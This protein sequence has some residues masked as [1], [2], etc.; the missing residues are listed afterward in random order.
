MS[1]RSRAILPLLVALLPLS[2]SAQRDRGKSEQG[3]PPIPAAKEGWREDDK[4]QPRVLPA[5]VR[6]FEAM[7][8][9]RIRRVAEP[10]ISP[11]GTTVLFTVTDTVFEDNRR[12]SRIWSVST[13]TGEPE[14]QLTTSDAG[15]DYQPRWSP[16]GSRIAFVSTRTGSAQIWTMK[17][18]GSDLRQVTEEPNGADG[19]VWSPDGKL[20]AF[21][22]ET[23]KP[24][25]GKPCSAAADYVAEKGGPKAKA[26]FADRLLYRHWDTWRD[27]VRTHVF[28][29]P[30]S[31]GA[32]RDLT[33]GDFDSPP[34]QVGDEADYV[35]SPDSKK[36]VYFR[37]VDPIEAISTN[38]DM[39]LVP[40]DGSAPPKNLTAENKARDIT[41]LWS[42]DGAGL[43]Y[44][45]AKRPGYEAD[46][47]SLWLYDAED[48]GR[49]DLM[50]EID[51]SVASFRWLPDSKRIVFSAV[52]EGSTPLF[53]LDT[54]T[55]KLEQ[56][57]AAGD[58]RSFD[59]SNDGKVAVWAG[60]AI[61][62]PAE[63]FLSN[64]AAPHPLQLTRVN[65]PLLRTVNLQK[66]RLID[67]EGAGKSRIKAYVLTPPGF[68]AK[69]RWPLLVWLHGGP[70][71]AWLD[72]FHYRWNPQPFVH[73]GFVVIMP[74]IHGS[75]GY[76]QAFTD[77]VSGDWGGKAY[78][79]V[80]GAVRYM[81]DTGYIDENRVGAMGA[82][83]GGYMVNWLM[84]KNHRFAA[85]MTH[86]GPYDIPA[87]WGSTEELWLPEWEFGGVPWEKKE[88][89]E[90]WNPA[91][92][93]GNFQ[94]PTL[95]THGELDYRVNVS[96]AYQLFSALQR[97]GVPSRLLV[98]PDEGHWVLKPQNS[99]LWYETAL[100][101]FGKWLKLK[102][103]DE[104]P[105]YFPAVKEKSA[106]RAAAGAEG[107][108]EIHESASA[109]PP[110]AK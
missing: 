11:D 6:P 69:K 82:S 65:A 44:R 1:V 16:D 61:D 42:P 104:L 79:D 14:K 52:A 50:P 10:R 29:V 103:R 9:F 19:P 18:D 92:F 51:L 95:V 49:K 84:G 59:V 39:F 106:A 36:L 22:S 75:E 89:F 43:A 110:P 41:A 90:K 62:H 73:A 34:F 40:L 26:H 48:G 56:L 68:N 101:W 67:Y 58:H 77:S 4:L 32:A 99:K 21:T 87:F 72:E 96:N 86:A 93:A 30:S 109:A 31:G 25:G 53:V 54:K 57:D 105:P 2:A 38:V 83:Y 71:S 5:G 27:G 64:L 8:L 78:E 46:K 102:G 23:D 74:N 13:V 35:F 55:K 108:A 7:D 107:R 24:C 80:M 45:A 88:G 97:K 70:Q 76:G 60:S 47:M 17:P 94:T 100:D 28:V 20:L 33:P 3:R 12:I 66:P 37:N 15:R 85:L 98:F 91:A 63:I 81:L